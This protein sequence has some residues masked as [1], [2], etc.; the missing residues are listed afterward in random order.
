MGTEYENLKKMWDT[1]YTPVTDEVVEILMLVKTE[2]GGS[3]QSLAQTIGIKPRHLRRLYNKT[4]RTVTLS[5]MDRILARSDYSYRL[6]DLP[7]LTCDDL[8]EQGIWGIPLPHVR[9]REQFEPV[10]DELSYPTTE[11]GS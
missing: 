10:Q 1:R 8:I 4:Q 5:L 7:W 2:W 6:H 11:D 9:Q 3:W